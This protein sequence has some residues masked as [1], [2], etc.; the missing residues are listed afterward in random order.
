MLFRAVSC[1]FVLFSKTTQLIGPAELVL[2]SYTNTISALRASRVERP[3]KSCVAPHFLT[4]QPNIC[5]RKM[6]HFGAIFLFPKPVGTLFGQ[7]AP[8]GTRNWPRENARRPVVWTARVFPRISP[9][10]VG[11]PQLASPQ[12]QLASC[13]FAPR[14]GAAQLS[15]PSNRAVASGT[16]LQI[17]LLPIQILCSALQ[18]GLFS[19]LAP[20]SGA[21]KPDRPQLSRESHAPS[22]ASY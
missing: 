6:F 1:C 7:K 17:V 10:E 19:Q 8:E 18:I 22:R 4:A 14:S 13:D 3:F 5:S 21:A 15:G 2:V 9:H 20:R 12:T 11:R 16:A